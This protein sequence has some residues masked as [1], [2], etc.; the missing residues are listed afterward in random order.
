MLREFKAFQA[1]DSRV[2]CDDKL[3]LIVIT[4]TSENNQKYL[5]KPT[6]SHNIKWLSL[7]QLCVY[8]GPFLVNVSTFLLDRSRGSNLMKEMSLF[9]HLNTN[10]NW[11]TWCEH[12]LF[13]SI[14]VCFSGRCG[15]IS[16][17]SS[18]QQV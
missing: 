17:D 4:E 10:L 1:Q 13:S 18:D 11:F 12:S 15:G 8:S 7:M 6:H 3:N 2:N 16:G 5:R 9:H 14:F